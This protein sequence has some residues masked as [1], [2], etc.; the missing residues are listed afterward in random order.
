MEDIKL[1]HEEITIL[2]L[3]SLNYDYYTILNPGHYKSVP[4][5][6]AGTLIEAILQLDTIPKVA[7][8]IEVGVQTLNRLLEKVL[9]PSLG[10]RNGGNDT[11]KLALLTKAGCKRCGSC[12]SI[13]KHNFFSKDS[14]S[15][16]GLSA[17]CNKCKSDYNTLQYKE[18][19]TKAAHTKSYIKNYSKILERNQ[20]YKG[21]RS[22]RCVK[23]ANKEKLVEFY[24]NCPEG[25]HVDH[26]LP[27]K[28]EL[29]S[30]LHVVENLQYLTAEENIKKGNRID[31]EA[32]NKALNPT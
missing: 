31:L 23:W 6:Y 32:Y 13:F 20:H 9:V 30:G 15:F 11:W 4:D 1:T 28:G 2:I 29:V 24:K 16:D 14:S 8:S 7:S 22:L 5:V 10:K 27:L 18:E 26:E 12:N 19:T 25:Y 21:E 3:D 17:R